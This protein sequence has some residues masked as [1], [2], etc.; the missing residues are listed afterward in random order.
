MSEN[1]IK[2]WVSEYEEEKNSQKNKTD[3]NS[4]L[5]RAKSDFIEEGFSKDPD[6]LDIEDKHFDSV[7]FDNFLVYLEWKDSYS[8]LAT[9]LA[10]Y[11]DKQKESIKNQLKQEVLK[12]TIK[13]KKNIDTLKDIYSKEYEIKSAEELEKKL[14]KLKSHELNTLINSELKRKKFIEKNY[15]K[16]EYKIIDDTEDFLKEINIEW[17]D[18]EKLEKW[19]KEAIQKFSDT[20]NLNPTEFLHFLSIFDKKQKIA[21]LKHF[22]VSI[23]LYDL[24]KEEI[25]DKNTA[26][27]LLEESIKNTYPKLEDK[28]I[29]K[30]S[31]NFLSNDLLLKDINLSIEEL[32][33]LWDKEIKNLLRN[34]EVLSNLSEKLSEKDIELAEWEL[35]EKLSLDEK[36]NIHQN[37]INLI[38]KDSKNTSETVRNSIDN[39]SEWNYIR[40][41]LNWKDSYYK[42]GATELWWDN[43]QEKLFKFTNLTSPFG[44][45]LIKPEQGNEE[46]MAY[47]NLYKVLK[48]A[49][50][51]KSSDVEFIN[52]KDFNKDWKLDFID[53]KNNISSQEDLKKKLVSIWKLDESL[54][55]TPLNELCFLDNKKKW[56]TPFYRYFQA[57]TDD[58][59][60]FEG[61]NQ[62]MSF[63]DFFAEI[64][65]EKD[66]KNEEDEIYQ[67]EKRIFSAWDIFEKEPLNSVA[68]HKD[69]NK[70]VNKDAKN[71]SKVW[72]VKL[73]INWNKDKWLYIHEASDW[74]I[75]YSLWSVKENKI[76]KKKLSDKELKKGKKEEIKEIKYE[77][78]DS[79]EWSSF[80]NYNDF[81]LH[82]KKFW[83]SPQFVDWTLIETEEDKKSKDIIE[84]EGGFMKKLFT[85][86][87]ILE[88]IQGW[89]MMVDAIKEH[90]E[91]WNKLRASKFAQKFW[92]MLPDTISTKLRSKAEKETNDLINER[93]DMWKVMWS[94]VATKDIKRNILLNKYAEDHEILAA[95]QYMVEKNGTLYA[96]ELKEFRPKPNSSYADHLWFRKLW[97]TKEQFENEKAK[98][99]KA[100]WQTAAWRDDPEVFSEEKLVMSVLA[101]WAKSQR[102][103]SKIHKDFWWKVETGHKKRMEKWVEETS[104][105]YTASDKVEY[106]LDYLWKWE[107]SRFLWAMEKTLWKDSDTYSMNVMPF[108]LWMSWLSRTW[109]SWQIQELHRL[110]WT[111]AYPTLEMM[112]SDEWVD[113]YQ[114]AIYTFLELS[115]NW[116]KIE[117]LK[118]LSEK[119]KTIDKNW[120]DSLHKF[121]MENKELLT[122]FIT[123]R[124]WFAATRRDKEPILWA[125]YDR[126][127]AKFNDP[128]YSLNEDS[129]KAKTYEKTALADAGA[130]LKNNLDIWSHNL[131]V[132]WTKSDRIFSV[133]TERLKEI[134]GLPSIEKNKSIWIKEEDR[135]KLFINVFDT[136]ENYLSKYIKPVYKRYENDL[137][138]FYAMD[139]PKRMKDN[140]LLISIWENETINRQEFLKKAYHH[141]MNWSSSSLWNINDEISDAMKDILEGKVEPKNTQKNAYEDENSDFENPFESLKNS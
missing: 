20:Q 113:L 126:I 111:T 91:H 79:W 58:W 5:N 118:K 11:S 29:K 43:I 110:D 37:F 134:K 21:I 35:N 55:D 88:L 48:N 1:Q 130:K 78:K 75:T 15:K 24:L 16:G 4:L 59:L 108:V 101:D 17:I 65:K 72:E 26:E 122:E 105:Y 18:I 104:M 46:T 140:N 68:L 36:W 62:K 76:P 96:K 22:K 141:F 103:P 106:A 116:D 94:D 125:Y 13:N 77:F 39:F 117:R 51:Q 115:W 114:E 32:E 60:V 70:I 56:D 45:W 74:K 98:I 28:E 138:T 112:K 7:A 81:L 41:N 132:R 107:W 109:H 129:I 100:N 14:K 42:I 120:W 133:Y 33:N 9:E 85:N 83:Y 57:I 131:D 31:Q 61:S 93:I 25:I 38:K 53:S 71:N 124:D 34:K 128:E 3:L 90:F 135:E 136:F 89:N 102:F 19:Q 52:T 10:G 127:K 121:F 44:E 73:F 82:V 2:E 64:E 50:K 67:F 95:M 12:N 66:N 92:K 54:V 8:F 63:S 40:I 97:W 30:F 47:E 69:W 6:F 123:L 87:S 86:S 119:G 139:A 23:N 84:K 137:D 49:N 27:K 80:D 99:T